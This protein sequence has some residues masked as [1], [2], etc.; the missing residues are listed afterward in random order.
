MTINDW[1]I[2]P[3]IGENKIHVPN[4][5]FVFHFWIGFVFFIFLGLAIY[6]III[7]PMVNNA[8]MCMVIFG[9]D[10]KRCCLSNCI[11][12]IKW[13]LG[14]LEIGTHMIIYPIYESI[15]SWIMPVNSTTNIEVLKPWN[16]RILTQL[17]QQKMPFLQQRSW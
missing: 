5:Q 17:K 14:P 9:L 15:V 4:H 13:D 6:T 2:I 12:Q 10:F 16:T 11:Y 1:I 3:T 8:K 7:N